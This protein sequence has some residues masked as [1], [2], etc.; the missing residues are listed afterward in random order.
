LLDHLATKL[1]EFRWSLKALH[2]YI[3]QS[4]AYR[5]SS[6][7]HPGNVRRDPGNRWY[8]RFDPQR[9]SAESIRDTLLYVSG[10]LDLT[11]GGAPVA[12]V[13]SQDPSPADLQK[14]RAVYE[15]S[16][17][18]SVYL[19]VVRTNVYKFFT[20]FDFPNPAAPT[21][22]RST[23]TIPTQALFLMNN[24]WVQGLADDIAGNV[25]RV[26]L[27]PEIRCQVLF[28]TLFGRMPMPEEVRDCLALVA[29][30][31]EEGATA[32]APLSGWK[33][34]VHTL[35]LSSEFIYVH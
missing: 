31:P 22:N 26:H 17:R 35:L 25:C 2:R 27:Q 32:D 15:G 23:T 7:Y 30:V 14:N 10:R 21:G 4:N 28:E 34:L 12:G 18:R 8:W 11:V 16:P 19:P 3:V 6:R 5:M 24:P 20:L 33:T 13:K 9:L 1:I 29:E